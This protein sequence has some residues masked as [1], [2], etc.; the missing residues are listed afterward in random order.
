M[1]PTGKLRVS[2]LASGSVGGSGLNYRPR[3]MEV[4]ISVGLASLS[5]CSRLEIQ[6]PSQ[7]H[8]YFV[9]SMRDDVRTIGMRDAR[10][11]PR[12]DWELIT[13]NVS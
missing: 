5:H 11:E 3:K 4:T 13:Y 8:L 2:C 10:V 12:T 7:F 9:A 6:L 1:V